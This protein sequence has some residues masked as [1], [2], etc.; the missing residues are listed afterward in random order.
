MGPYHLSANR[1]NG[2]DANIKFD[3]DV[4]IRCIVAV[5]CLWLEDC[6]TKLV[7]PLYHIS[8]EAT[9]HLGITY[10]ARL[11]MISIAKH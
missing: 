1:D 9:K 8:E 2:Y 5:A 10:I 11:K 3:D 7:L 6:Q 4:H